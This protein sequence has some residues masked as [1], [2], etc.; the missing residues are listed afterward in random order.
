MAQVNTD[1]IKTHLASLI[2]QEFFPERF[3]LIDVDKLKIYYV[4]T[5]KVV[6]VVK[7]N[8]SKK[9]SKT[10]P[11]ISTLFLETHTCR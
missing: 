9:L 4:N 3:P 6:E 8:D 1:Y 11:V 7:F 10:L 5:G 2:K